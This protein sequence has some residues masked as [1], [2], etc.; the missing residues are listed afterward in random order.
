MHSS[1]LKHF[2]KHFVCLFVSRFL[3]HTP[4]SPFQNLEKCWRCRST[5]WR[6][7]WRRTAFWVPWWTILESSTSH[8]KTTTGAPLSSP[9][10]PPSPC[11]PPSAP[12]SRHSTAPPSSPPPTAPAPTPTSSS[13]TSSRPTPNPLSWTSKSAPEHGTS[14][15]P[16]T[17][18]PN[19]STKIEP[20]Q[21]SPSAS[22]SPA[23]RTPSPPGNLPEPF[24]KPFPLRASLWS[25]ANLSPPPT[26]TIL[27]PT[28][29]A[30]LRRRFWAPSSSG[31]WSWKRGLR[32]RLYII[33]ILV[34]FWWCMRRRRGTPSLWSNLL[35]LLM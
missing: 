18:S 12:S 29:I 25:S 32:F 30:T 35:I 7:T 22:E 14:V 16:K 8:C 15:T 17:T 21:P 20:P 5:R 33:S 34:L 2:I 28:P 13:R 31:W 4:S 11:H 10:T 1:F 26:P 6:V 9:S 3:S 27:S 23:S 24:S 19:V